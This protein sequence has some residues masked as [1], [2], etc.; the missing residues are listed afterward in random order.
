MADDRV[1]TPSG[2]VTL[3]GIGDTGI[4]PDGQAVG[5]LPTQAQIDAAKGA[6]IPVAQGLQ[7]MRREE[8]WKKAQTVSIGPSA[9][10]IESGAGTPEQIRLAKEG[11]EKLRQQ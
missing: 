8:D 11:E 4:R 2:S 1:I 6:G 3:P 5:S 10:T 9:S 7:D